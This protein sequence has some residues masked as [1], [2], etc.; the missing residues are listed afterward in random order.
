MSNS[1]SAGGLVSTAIDLYRFDKALKENRFLSSRM[2]SRMLTAESYGYGYGWNIAITEKII[3]LYF[4][5]EELTALRPP[6]YD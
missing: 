6:I 4:I 3:N 2:T 5:T 1:Y